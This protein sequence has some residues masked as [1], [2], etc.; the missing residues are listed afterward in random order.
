MLSCN[1]RLVRREG[2]YVLFRYKDYQ[3]GGRWR[4]DRVH[5]LEL[6]RRFLLHVLPHR[7]RLSELIARP[8]PAP[9]PWANPRVTRGPPKP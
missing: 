3:R 6:I 1:E 4:I 2:E 8:R 5:A 7:S 9:S